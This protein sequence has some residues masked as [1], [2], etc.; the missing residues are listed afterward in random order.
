MASN[1][2][3]FI[4]EN[5][6]FGNQDKWVERGDII[7]KN[8]DQWIE[9]DWVEIN[10]T[11]KTSTIQK[12]KNMIPLFGYFSIYAV[13]AFVI[14]DP[15]N[16][17]GIYQMD[18]ALQAL[19][20]PV[21]GYVLVSYRSFDSFIKSVF[22]SI[23]LL[24]F[25]YLPLLSGDIITFN[26]IIFLRYIIWFIR[27]VEPDAMSD[28]EIMAPMEVVETTAGLIVGLFFIEFFIMVVYNIFKR[29]DKAD[30]VIS[31]S[32]VFF[33]TKTRKSFFE[34]IKIGFFILTNP[35]NINN[36]REA[37]LLRKYHKLSAEEGKNWDF[38]KIPVDAVFEL[39]KKKISKIKKIIIGSV[40]IFFGLTIFLPLFLIG[41][42]ILL[43]CFSK[44]K[45]FNITIKFDR[46]KILG[47]W[48][49]INTANS[50]KLKKVPEHF[51]NFFSPINA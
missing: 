20:L 40:S 44:R 32:N 46:E 45:F 5:E 35:F 17:N 33:R 8:N 18:E 24:Y 37:T 9:N 7:L 34:I 29:S 6:P 1:P 13:I 16:P 10:F 30:L 22:S 4:D 11:K 2:P 26:G 27:T 41:I 51:A 31:K 28:M 48:Q 42:V 50:I 23:F 14:T 21:L 39:K 43:S 38:G 3:F 19:F 12:I 15:S 47:S 49:L 36:Y 25:F